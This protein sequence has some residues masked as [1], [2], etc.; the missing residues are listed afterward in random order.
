VFCLQSERLSWQVTFR[1]YCDSHFFQLLLFMNKC[2]SIHLSLQSVPIS[3]PPVPAL[4]LVNPGAESPIH[5]SSLISGLYQS[6]LTWNKTETSFKNFYHDSN[7]ESGTRQGTNGLFFHWTWQ[8]ICISTNKEHMQGL[9]CNLEKI[10]SNW[11]KP[12]SVYGNA[13]FNL[14]EIAK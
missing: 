3:A 4:P 13:F 1:K 8:N 5:L 9:N 10:Q 11:S 2:W 14:K 6:T 7:R 12:V